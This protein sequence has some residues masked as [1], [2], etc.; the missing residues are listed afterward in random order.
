MVELPPPDDD[1]MMKITFGSYWPVLFLLGIPFLWWMRKRTATLLSR[2]HLSLL[3]TVRTAIIVALALALMRPVW[4][5]SGRWLSV[6]FALDVS[7]SISPSFIDSTLKWM[8]AAVEEASPSHTR[9][10]AFASDAIVVENVEELSSVPVTR[11]DSVSPGALDQ[12][13]THIEKALARSLRSFDSNSLK[14]LVLVTDGQET[15]GDLSGPILQAEREGVRVFTLPAEVRADSDSWIDAVEVPDDVSA[16]EPFEVVVQVFSRAPQ[17]GLLELGRVNGESLASKPID[18][19]AGPSRHSFE[20]RIE[21]TG[22]VSIEARLT[23]E[24]DPFPDNNRERRSLWIGE[25][26][27]LLYVEGHPESARYLADALGDEGF[28]VT[29]ATAS[30]LPRS[31]QAL[32]A[33]DAVILSDVSASRLDEQKMQSLRE[34]VRDGGGGLIFIGGETSYGASG[35]SETPVEE[36]LPIS[37]D[38]KEKRKD[39][40][41]VIVLD[42]SY[43]MEGEKIEL[44]KEATKAALDLL[45]DTHYF[46]LVTF[47]WY[48]KL[49]IPLQLANDKRRLHDIIGKIK[50]SAPTRIYPALEEAHL[51][52]A[53]NESKIKHVIV[54]SDGMSYRLADGGEGQINDMVADGLTISTVAVGLEADR[55]LLQNIARW[56]NGRTYFTEDASRVPEIFFR[57]AEIA[58]QDT[59]SEEL[60]QPKVTQ[61]IEAFQGIDFDTAPPLKGYVSTQ[62]KTTAEVLL[63]AEPDDD[64]ILAR[65]HYGLGKAVAFTSDA[66]NRWASD[67]LSWEGYGKFWAQITR[68]TMR[69]NRNLLDLRVYREGDKAVVKLDA[70]DRQG[71]YLNGMEPHIDLVGPNGNESRE[72]APQVGPGAYQLE[73]P[74]SIDPDSHSLFNIETGAL[75][76]ESEEVGSRAVFYSFPDEYRFRPANTELLGSI[77]ERTGGQLDPE[78]EDIFA[79]HGGT[80]TRPMPLWPILAGFALILYLLDIG[81]RRAPWLWDKFQQD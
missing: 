23:A 76:P 26:P 10:V 32:D 52:L 64:P 17:V 68:K 3:V 53:D 42:K 29:V 1:L 55:E 77:S 50:A 7:G 8:A 25:R 20:I 43:S 61:A 65:W 2:R 33:Y 66:K 46:G 21:E 57:E 36:A 16:G 45:D 11:G 34:Y 35:Y 70:M 19:P 30:G 56:G 5:R 31:A 15:K 28:E 54:L 39:V 71:L 24:R 51:Q 81:I 60:F 22:S 73:L 14:H 79:Y 37:F 62:P 47:D 63:V 74:L 6:V 13:E 80:A 59:L 9:F 18:L 69:Q 12:R 41:L 67:W 40:S 27:K 38:I 48:P 49:M 75:H 44:A 4:H 78:I 58:V 72:L